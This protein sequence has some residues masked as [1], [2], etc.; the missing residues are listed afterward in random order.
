MCLILENI[1]FV[2]FSLRVKYLLSC[3]YL[4]FCNILADFHSFFK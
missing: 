3:V 1:Q 2:L 4:V